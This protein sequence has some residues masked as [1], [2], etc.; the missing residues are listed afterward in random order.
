MAILKCPH[1]HR[2]MM[3]EEETCPA[4]GISI[5]ASTSLQKWI[6]QMK[7]YAAA[8]VIGIILLAVSLPRLMQQLQASSPDQGLMII[9]ASGGLAVVI[10]I[11]GL[12]LSF[13]FY[14]DGKSKT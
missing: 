6:V 9:S 1:C 3:K 4:C 2:G 5:A 11:V 13:Y 7:I 14:R 12:A 8:I 10:G